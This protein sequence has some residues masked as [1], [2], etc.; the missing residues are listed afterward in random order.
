MQGSALRITSGGNFAPTLVPEPLLIIR[1]ANVQSQNSLRFVDE[2]ISRLNLQ[3][4]PPP[5]ELEVRLE[6]LAQVSGISVLQLGALLEKCPEVIH[7]PANAIKSRVNQYTKIWKPRQL[8]RCIAQYPGILTNSFQIQLQ[9]S[10]QELTDLGFTREQTGKIIV[11]CPNIVG[12]NSNRILNHLQRNGI[13]LLSETGHTYDFFTRHPQYLL[14]EG[15]TSLAEFIDLFGTYGMPPQRS[16]QAVRLCPKLLT[17]SVDQARLVI[18]VLLSF[19]MSQA[20]LESLLVKYPSVLR[21]DARRVKAT[22]RILAAFDISLEKLIKYP[23]VFIHN[24]SHVVG[25][26][27]AYLR[28]YAPELLKNLALVTIMSR[29]DDEFCEKYCSGPHEEFLVF[30]EQWAAQAEGVTYARSR[31]VT[32]RFGEAMAEKLR[33]EITTELWH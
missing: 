12:V 25:P 5:Q 29:S 6:V 2:C 23:R 33:E 9:T 32:S 24:P 8:Q 14:P 3:S 19:A 1:A 18:E 30:Q 31:K 26:R 21:L 7:V 10:L 16:L 15:P 11:K 27:L 28:S 13:D 20:Q 17:M 4:I 22:M